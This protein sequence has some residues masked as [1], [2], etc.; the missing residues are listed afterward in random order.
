MRW[1]RI[2][3]ALIMGLIERWRPETSTFHL[4]SGE[5]TITL[6]DVAYIYA[7]PIDS[8]P[9]TGRTYTHNEID[10]LCRELLGV[11]LWLQQRFMD[12]GWSVPMN[13]TMTTKTD[14]PLQ[15]NGNDCGLFACAFAEH[16]VYRCPIEFT[17]SDF[18]YYR[19]RIIIDIF[20][21]N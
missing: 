15:D 8:P 14:I 11:R 13:W 2:D 9:V 21:Q 10:D 6:E 19:Q 3:H 4:P 5:A 16:C 20:E 17:Q 12:H 7:L 1:M 18:P